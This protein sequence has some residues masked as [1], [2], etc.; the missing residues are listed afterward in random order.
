MDKRFTQN[1]KQNG[2]SLVELMIASVIVLMILGILSTLILGINRTYSQQRPRIEAVNDATAALDMIGR[3]VRMAGNNPNGI[4][5]LQGIDPGMPVSGQYNTIR[6][7]SDWHGATSDSAPD[8]DTDDVF[9]DTTFSVSAGKLRKQELPG[10][11]L[12]VEFLENVNSLRF[13]YYDTNNLLI[14]DPVT[15]QSAI[16]RVDI[17]IDTQL[18]DSP[19]MTFGT[20]IHLRGT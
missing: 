6:I 17:E 14:A 4:A 16:A 19:V 8:G 9:E 20:S 2:F 10:D 3:L 15:N 7:R 5:G 13:T 18:P 1:R 11:L 12:P